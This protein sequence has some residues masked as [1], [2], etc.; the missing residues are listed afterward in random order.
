MFL[1]KITSSK[2]FQAYYSWIFFFNFYATSKHVL[3]MYF[4]EKTSNNFNS[5]L[6]GSFWKF[7]K[8]YCLLFMTYSM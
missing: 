2:N 1:K 3:S 7:K 5:I 6:H 4:L 8:H